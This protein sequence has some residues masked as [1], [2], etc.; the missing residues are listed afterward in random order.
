M[1]N[2]QSTL[3]I[4]TILGIASVLLCFGAKSYGFPAS[5]YAENSVLSQG[6]WAKIEVTETGMQF[7]S[8]ATLRNLGFSDP[9]KVNVFGYGGEEISENLDSPDDLPVVASIR[10]NGGIIFFG[11][12][13][14]AWT[15]NTSDRTTL[16][17]HIS[18]SYSDKSY[19]FVSDLLGERQTPENDETIASSGEKITE[20]TERL[21]HEQD[22]S[23]PM[24]S[25]RLMLGEDFR[26]TPTRSFK[27]Q[28]PGNLGN[29]TVVTAFGCKTSSGTS[30]LVFT[31]NGK[32][33]SA[34]S[35]DKMA[36][37]ES[38]LVVTTK[39]VK[40]IE[41]PGTT[42]DFN[43]KFNGS[44]NVTIAGLNYIE[45][46][47][48]RALNVGNGEL[49]FYIEPHQ[50]SDIIIEGASSAVQV[51]DVTDATS[52]LLMETELNGSSLSFVSK[53]GYREYVAFDPSR[54]T[55]AVLPGSSVVNQNIHSMEAPGMLVISP[56]EYLPAAQ[57]L[58]ELHQ[59]TDG[60]DVIVLTPEEIYNEFSS[61]KPDVSAFRKLLKMWYDRSQDSEDGDYT[62]YCLIMSRPTYDNK[63][64]T[65][66][67]QKA[68]YP[69]IPI[70]QS[71]T[72][73]TATTTYSTDDYIGMVG[74]TYG[75]FNI[76]TAEIQVA[77]GRMPVKSLSEANSAVDKLES[78]LL[79]PDTGSWRNNVMIIADDQDNGTHL[80]QA[81]KVA[82]ALQSNDFGRSFNYEKLYLDSYPLEY[83][84]VGASYPLAKERML[85]KWN[86]GL[87]YIDY[88]GHANPKGWGHE[89]LLTWPD[90]NSMSNARL[91]I[92]YAATCEF[93]RWD[94]DDISG[95]E[96]L[97][98]MP[99]SGI[100]ASICPSREVLITANGTL[101]QATAQYMF[102]RDKDGKPLTC[103]EI[104]IKGKNA[105]NTGS[106]KLRYGL[107]GDPSMRMPWPE[108]RVIVDSINGIELENAEDFPV[109]SARSNVTVS[110]HM[111]DESG[112][113]LS[114]FNGI[115]E[116][117][118]FDAEKVIT[119]NGNGSDGVVSV[120]NDRKTRLFVGRTK[121]VDGEW[122]TSF[123]MPSE[124]ENNYM[125]AL[126]SLYAYEDGGRE[127]NGYTE[128]LYA[129][130][131][132]STAPDD[133]EGP[134]IL[135]IY[136]GS[137]SFN[138]GDQ[139]SPNPTLFAKF[140]D[141][142]GISVS[143]AGIGHNITLELD[144][145][146]FFD[147][148]AQY[149]L[150]DENAPGTG[151]LTY[152]LNDIEQGTHS[153]KFTVWDNANNSTS[154]TIDFSISALWKPSIETL[155]TD[156][157]PATSSV[158]F[159]VATDGSTS[160]MECSIEV[161]N[162]WGKRVWR[163][164]APSLSKSSTRTTL[165]WDLCD[166]GGSRV[167]GGVYL[168]KATVKTDVGATVTKTKKLIVRGQ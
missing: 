135:E 6:Q 96:V 133:F 62:K 91:P 148:V 79:N 167:P 106:N 17:S 19:Y 103:G 56:L 21:V 16:Y 125:P 23:V 41:N 123:S 159:I 137:P 152:S 50:A 49:Y 110:G 42:L 70:W 164:Q 166:F 58:V 33:L 48:P 35:S 46:E 130:G 60:L 158:N 151:S 143:E 37:S 99:S 165:G 140:Y 64:V 65:T 115:A 94:E 28:L 122:S 76:T 67:V 57:R 82:E 87:A 119:T 102:Q 145:T 9:E 71:S 68:G 54:V 44:G 109:L 160:S 27:F 161:F 55:R 63:M 7:I 105:S 118:L 36:S 149:Y 30:S 144:G 25:G 86:E 74:D 104:M 107:I 147:D 12:G 139:V 97:W 8:D 90:I 117:T 95:A 162:L 47:Y 114:D 155:T 45:V 126:L 38:K 92:L 163:Q 18:H 24:F 136:L 120:Y 32:Q 138:S 59:L 77:V 20:F 80:N 51:W 61:G 142:S 83:T 134:K 5:H 3:R 81:E 40:E 66:V 52:P 1:P 93:L 4:K 10:V 131:Y 124:I 29:A 111:E 127:G 112:N 2:H 132:D 116:I 88:I 22:L 150:P 146:T 141:E 101:N 78:Y 75:S 43:I 157:N 11:K 69:R 13:S 26:S 31:A 34:G 154:A 53:P 98:L 153:L 15:K 14:V 156:V 39:S 113:L 121:V 100:I 108:H 89:N 84:G 73:E 129:Y 72:G 128:K 85:N 168:Y